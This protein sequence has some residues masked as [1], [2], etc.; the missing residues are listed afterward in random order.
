MAEN[1]SPELLELVTETV[2][3]IAAAPATAVMLIAGTLTL[4]RAL[5]L[6]LNVTGIT[7]GA[8]VEPGTVTVTFPLHTCWAKPC[9][10]AVT[11]I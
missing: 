4:R 5:L 10:L 2:C 1:A 6:T 7:S 9:G 8:V 3:V 11:T